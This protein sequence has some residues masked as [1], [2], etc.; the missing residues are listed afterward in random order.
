MVLSPN[1][2]ATFKVTLAIIIT[3]AVTF[4]SFVP[5]LKN[6]FTNFDDDK[7]VVDN[8]SIRKIAPENIKEIFS[9]FYMGNY[10]PLAILS[11]SLEYK[12][13]KLNP[14]PYHITNLAIHLF[15]CILVFWFIYLLSQSIPIAFITALF[16]GIHPLHVESVAW[17]AQRKDVLYGMFFLGAL[18]SYL[19]YLR[20]QYSRDFYFLSLLLF[21]CS[22]LSKSMAVT[23]PLALLLC[24][25][26]RGRPWGKKMLGEK[27]VFF[28]FSLTF[29]VIAVFSQL[30][31]GA[32]R[33]EAVPSLIRGI[34]V[35]F[36]AMQFYLMKLFVPYKLSCIYP[37]SNTSIATLPWFFYL[38]PLITATSAAALI[39]SR[40]YAKKEI[41]GSLFFLCTLLPVLQIIPFSNALAADR[42]T[43][44]PSIGIFFVV[45]SLFVRVYLKNN[46]YTKAVLITLLFATTCMLSI[47]TWNRCKVWRNSASLFKDALTQYAD[48]RIVHTNLGAA[49][50]D[51]K[52]FK[53]AV[54]SFNKA[55]QADPAN[56]YAYTDL[57]NAF[58]MLGKYSE[59]IAC[60]K[61]AIQLH[62]N[63]KKAY[64]NLGNAY[65]ELKKYNLAQDAFRTAIR[66]DP[67]Y[68]DAYCNLATVY[69]ENG[70]Y[71]TAIPLFKKSLEINP[72]LAEANYDLALIYTKQEEYGLAIYHLDRALQFKF[73]AEQ[74][75][76]DALAPYR[77][78][79]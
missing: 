4:L 76:L 40:K 56:Y 52:D 47:L 71:E 31:A 32:I 30:G 6:D 13:F 78:A 10:Q 34:L 55:I 36:F 17:V 29:A 16:F 72:D 14:T 39:Y 41:F 49:Y 37:Y 75:L 58:N 23:L 60:C 57:C 54:G 51:K 22:L 38:A 79:K 68:A 35:G 9:S 77:K 67:D 74:E 15:N 53:K 48:S 66:I 61:K 28:I 73:Q 18:I 20:K 64:F 11:Y 1:K 12:F 65:A 42:H 19:Y 26:Y 50:F 24:D 70:G 45:S 46:K 33:T 3:L 25:Y 62:P 59:A 5:S 2:K 69:W 7:Y 44:I 21:I 8:N 27:A 43:Y 63:N